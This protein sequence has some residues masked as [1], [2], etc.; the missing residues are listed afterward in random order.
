M[1]SQ[2]L[3]DR[4]F[5]PSAFRAGWTWENNE[6]SKFLESVIPFDFSGNPPLLRHD[7]FHDPVSNVFDWSEMQVRWGYYHPSESNYQ[8]PGDMNRAVFACLSYTMFNR[9][10]DRAFTRARSGKCAV[11]VADYLHNTATMLPHLRSVHEALIDRS[12]TYGVD[13]VFVTASELAKIAISSVDSLA[14]NLTISDQEVPSD[15][16][17]T[18]VSSEPLFADPYVVARCEGIPYI[19]LEPERINE[20]TWTVEISCLCGN[21]LL[22]ITVGACDQSGNTVIVSKRLGSTGT[23]EYHTN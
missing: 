2:L 15:S 1:L 10:L 5:S 22:G 18:I 16:I 23:P 20:T 6:M 14:P 11:V 17:L 4:H 21:S 9:A 3:I 7:Y 19:R 12:S 8:L 13:F